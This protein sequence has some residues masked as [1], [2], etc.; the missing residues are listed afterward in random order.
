MDGAYFFHIF[1]S[2]VKYYR[3]GMIGKLKTVAC[4]TMVI[5]ISA[6]G[7]TS[8]TATKSSINNDNR[9]YAM[10]LDA[11][12]QTTLPG[13]PAPGEGPTTEYKFIIVWTSQTKP[14]TFFWKNNDIWAPCRVSKISHYHPNS[15]KDL[16]SNTYIAEEASLFKIA[17]NDTLE[18]KPIF[19]SKNPPPDNLPQTINAI[20]YKATKTDWLTLP[21]DKTTELPDIIM[22]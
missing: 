8:K 21:V 18:L 13:R 22:Q 1:T 2:L 5:A 17:Q 19:G 7:Q 11:F 4:A 15:N 10:L 3:F 14:E 20:F 12:Q 9:G 6:C 16:Y